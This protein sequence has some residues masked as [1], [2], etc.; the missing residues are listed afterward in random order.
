MTLLLDKSIRTI[1]TA[2]GA[3]LEQQRQRD[4]GLTLREFVEQ[5]TPA[6]APPRAESAGQLA[7]AGDCFSN[8]EHK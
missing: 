4:S 6:V 8:G 5:E 1:L 3:S 2:A 7:G